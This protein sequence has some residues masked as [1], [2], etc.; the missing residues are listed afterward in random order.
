MR[1]KQMYRT[2][3]EKPV[4]LSN[5]QKILPGADETFDERT[6]HFLKRVFD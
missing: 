1:F 2:K 3:P 4:H 6:I 5:W